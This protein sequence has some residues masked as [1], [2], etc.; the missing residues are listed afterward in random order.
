MPTKDDLGGGLTLFDVTTGKELSN[1]DN[2]H[3]DSCKVEKGTQIGNWMR[4]NASITME[5]TIDG[6]VDI[7]KIL[8]LDIAHM[9]DSYTIQYIKLVQTRKHKKKRINKKWL[10]R[11]G[12]KKV[13]VNSEGWNVITHT[14][15][16]VEFV[17]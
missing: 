11:Y 15:G 8:G 7:N 14:D 12:Y 4:Q 9:P 6:K 3:L 2:V 5:F 1:I 17:K 10:K 13:I 16:T